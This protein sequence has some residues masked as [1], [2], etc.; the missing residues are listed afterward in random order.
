MLDVILEFRIFLIIFWFFFLEKRN[1]GGTKLSESFINTS[2]SQFFLYCFTSL[3]DHYNVG[4]ALGQTFSPH[5]LLLNLPL[6]STLFLFFFCAAPLLLWR[7]KCGFNLK[8]FSHQL[9]L[10]NTAM[11]ECTHIVFLPAATDPAVCPF[12]NHTIIF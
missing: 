8:N 7:V 6:L 1:I 9:T 12:P 4:A 10:N 11:L 3:Q 5:A 2:P